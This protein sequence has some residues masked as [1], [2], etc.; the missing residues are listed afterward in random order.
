[1]PGRL[2]AQVDDLD[3]GPAGALERPGRTQR[4][5]RRRGTAASTVGAGTDER[6]RAPARARALDRDLARVPRRRPFLLQRLVAVVEHDDARQ[7]GH[8][9]EHGQPPAD[10]DAAPARAASHIAVRSAAG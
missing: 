10:D 5:R 8:G 6:D 2:V 7:V 4:R 3:D 9:R 1:M